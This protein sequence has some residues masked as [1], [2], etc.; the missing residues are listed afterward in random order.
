MGKKKAVIEQTGSSETP[1]ELVQ[2]YQTVFQRLCDRYGCPTWKRHMPPVDELVSTILS[3]STSDGNRDRGFNALKA[4]FPD[5]Q[6]VMEAPQEE[7]IALIRPAGLSNQKGPR[8]QAALRTI[9]EEQGSIELDFL[10]DL[11]LE[12]AKTWL[13][14]LKGVG[15]KTAA[16][17]LLFTFNKPVFPVD[18]H[19]HRITKRLGLIGPKVSAA[20]AHSILEEMGDPVTFYPFHINLIRHGRETCLARNPR[21]GRCPLQNQC[22]AFKTKYSKL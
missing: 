14:Q 8:I 2:K 9:H 16:I 19:V 15:P 17:I 20:K 5:W 21:C 6:A 1:A 7:V 11:P 22:I 18:T 10:E 13:T 3:Q 4:H 12:E